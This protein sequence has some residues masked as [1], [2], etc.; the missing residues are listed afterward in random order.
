MCQ[1]LDLAL[2]EIRLGESKTDDNWPQKKAKEEKRS[3]GQESVQ[4][5][6]R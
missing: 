2:S 1:I 3:R 5:L 4:K 6:E